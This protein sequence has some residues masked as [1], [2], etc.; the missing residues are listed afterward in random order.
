MSVLSGGGGVVRGHA[1]RIRER[2]GPS[3]ERAAPR[4]PPHDHHLLLAPASALD[5][6][7]AL[8][9]ALRLEKKLILVPL[10][11]REQWLKTC[12]EQMRRAGPFGRVDLLLEWD[13]QDASNVWLDWEGFQEELGAATGVR[14][15][16]VCCRPVFEVW[17]LLHFESLG[18]EWE[19]GEWVRERARQCLESLP[20]SGSATLWERTASRLGLAV[21]RSKAMAWQRVAGA[22]DDDRL[23]VVPGTHLHE[24]IRAWYRMARCDL[25][26]G[27]DAPGAEPT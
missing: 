11:P 4:R 3:L 10:P 1:S 27:D 16:L 9:T 6:L 20:D 25:P 22:G 8:I 18:P 23:P 26:S 14:P 19:H 17:I 21:R 5:Y 12:R 2:A 15:R 7:G 24:W 13:G